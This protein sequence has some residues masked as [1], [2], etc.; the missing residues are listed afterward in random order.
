M[1]IQPYPQPSDVLPA[2]SLTVHDQR[3]IQDALDSSTSANTRRAYNQAW[4]RFVAWAEARGIPALPAT[5]ELAAAFLADRAGLANRRLTGGNFRDLAGFRGAGSE[6]IVLGAEMRPWKT[7]G[8]E[9]GSP[10]R[11]KRAADGPER[12]Q[13]AVSGAPDSSR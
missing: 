6:A 7:E 12:A 10:G 8:V 13:R 3:R 4:R 2:Q 9:K 1:T 5:P 11:E